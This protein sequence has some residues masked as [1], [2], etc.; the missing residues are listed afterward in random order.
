[1]RVRLSF[2]DLKTVLILRV[3]AST[4]M[5]CWTPF[6]IVFDVWTKAEIKVSSDVMRKIVPNLLVEADTSTSWA[7]RRPNISVLTAFAPVMRV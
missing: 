4:E 6:R 3:S 2:V 5:G 7:V 1:L